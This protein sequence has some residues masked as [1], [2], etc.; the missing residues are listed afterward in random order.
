MGPSTDSGGRGLAIGGL[1]CGG[2]G[3]MMGIAVHMF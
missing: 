2:V 3:L 1:V